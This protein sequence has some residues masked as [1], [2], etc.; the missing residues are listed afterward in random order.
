MTGSIKIVG[1][2]LL[3]VIMQGCLVFHT[4]SYKINLQDEKSG[5]VK[6]EVEDIRSDA[7]NSSEL[8]EDKLQLFYFL[9]LYA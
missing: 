5:T 1:F 8:E 3:A 4:V 6:M 9:L 2:F 7:M